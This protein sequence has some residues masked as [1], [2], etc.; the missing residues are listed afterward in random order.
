MSAI[1]QPREIHASLFFY[2]A[3]NS[4]DY[5]FNSK[6]IYFILKGYIRL[7]SSK[8]HQNQINQNFLILLRKTGAGDVQNKTTF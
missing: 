8:T 1:P 5:S 4:I 7:S 6:D 2:T 3:A